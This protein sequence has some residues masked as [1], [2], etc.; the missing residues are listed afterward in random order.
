MIKKNGYPVESHV[1][2][3]EDGYLLTMHR[4]PHGKP[5]ANGEVPAEK[6]VVFLQHGVLSCSADWVVIGPE[7]ALAYLLADQGYDVWMGNARGNTYSRSHTTLDPDDD[8]AFWQFSWHEIGTIDV[9]AMIDFILEETSEEKLHYIGH[10]QGT[11]VLFVMLSLKPAYNDVLYSA[12]ALAPIVFVS[13]LKSPILR[14]VAPLSDQL[15]LLSGLIGVNEFMPSNV[16]TRI[17][18]K[19]ACMDHSPFQEICANMLFL[20]AGYDSEQLNRV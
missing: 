15:D 11:T 18:G 3:T 14:L 10:S 1:V 4:I 9:P 12:Q 2:E 17:G 8:A 20:I 6:S 19:Y 16:F 7:N 5:D 13:H